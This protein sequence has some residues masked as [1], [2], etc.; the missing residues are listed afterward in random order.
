[1]QAL[2]VEQVVW[3][4]QPTF[5]GLIKHPGAPSVPTKR[6]VSPSL[7]SSRP[8]HSVRPVIAYHT[9]QDQE[10]RLLGEIPECLR[11][12]DNPAWLKH[13]ANVD[14]RNQRFA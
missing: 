8:L 5:S 14:R 6:C 11:K 3:A 13:R 4:W 1:V 9:V 10:R 7:A 12:I 2:V